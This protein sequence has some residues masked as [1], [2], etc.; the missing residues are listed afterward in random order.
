MW[1]FADQSLKERKTRLY[2]QTLPP[3]SPVAG[4]CHSPGISAT[5]QDGG[6]QNVECLSPANSHQQ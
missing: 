2:Q 3:N 4:T 1:T 5:D 6:G